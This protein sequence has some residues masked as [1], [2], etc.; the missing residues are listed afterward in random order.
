MNHRQTMEIIIMT[1]PLKLVATLKHLQTMITVPRQIVKTILIMI[2]KTI[3]ITIVKTI[4]IAIVKTTISLIRIAIMVKHVLPMEVKLFSPIYSSLPY[5]LKQFQE[6]V[7]KLKQN[8]VN[9]FLNIKLLIN[10]MI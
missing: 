1:I 9:C 7:K 5:Y 3:A 8:F 10:Q 4:L 2:V 6:K